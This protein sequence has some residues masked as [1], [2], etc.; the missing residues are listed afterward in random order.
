M[1]IKRNVRF[2]YQIINIKLVSKHR[3]G[4]DAYRQ[5]IEDIYN[6]SIKKPTSRGKMVIIRN[7]FPTEL[8]GN[9][10]YYGKISRFTNRETE[11]W[12]NL[13]TKEIEHPDFDPN[14][15]PNLQ[16]TEFVFIPQAHRFIIRKSTEFTIYNVED[17]LKKAIREVLGSDEDFSVIIEQSRDIYESI[18]NA[19]SVE[20]LLIKISYT[21][22]DD[23]GEDAV[24]WM[25][26]ELKEAHTQK[27]T[28][29]FEANPNEGINLETKLVKGALG[30]SVENGEAE[31]TV[32]GFDNR[33]KKI[34]TKKHPR[35]VRTSAGN[36]DEVKNVI[37]IET[38]ANY[39]PN[40]GDNE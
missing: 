38:M 40:G 2:N 20:R 11:D 9:K 22:S 36:E 17:F 32:I 3:K 10:F 27:A 6:N 1:R 4:T 35:E 19:K 5:I 23:I 31:A 29:Q 26:D 13:S 18:Y 28:L 39:R 21:N 16:E 7:M 33:R 12:I 14:L 25:D 8:D 30:L 15:F 37:F 24:E 34:I